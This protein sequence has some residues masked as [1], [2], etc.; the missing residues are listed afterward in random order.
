MSSA[1]AQSTVAPSSGFFDDVGAQPQ[2][3][4]VFDLPKSSS[5]SASV[6]SH[7]YSPNFAAAIP[8]DKN[9][10]DIFP[11]DS[12]DPTNPLDMPAPAASHFNW[13][14]ATQESLLYTGIMHVFDL[15]TEAGTRYTLNGHWFQNYIRSVSELRG[16]IEM[17]AGI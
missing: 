13:R 11:T 17:G 12:A 15:T 1:A 8:T 3:L 7:F 16:W 14:V 10:F 6:Y 4:L 5:Q 9:S 2:A